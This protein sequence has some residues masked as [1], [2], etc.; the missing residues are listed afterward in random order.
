[1]FFIR[2]YAYACVSHVCSDAT[3]HSTPQHNLTHLTIPGRA[4][5]VWNI[6]PPNLIFFLF[7]LLWTLYKIWFKGLSIFNS[8]NVGLRL[9]IRK[10]NGHKVFLCFMSFQSQQK[11]FIDQTHSLFG[12][13]LMFVL[14]TIPECLVWLWT[15]IETFCILF[16]FRVQTST[17][18]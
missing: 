4:C 12:Q 7:G 16:Q 17:L 2:G 3:N 1:M 6:F 9:E 5:N 18:A 10:N 11:L 8:F 13:K 14:E 15:T